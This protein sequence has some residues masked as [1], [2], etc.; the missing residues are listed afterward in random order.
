MTVGLSYNKLFKLLIDRNMKKGDLCVAANVAPS[1]LAKLRNGENVNT[2]ILVRICR[3]L[4]CEPGDI[5]EL[6]NEDAPEWRDAKMKPAKTQN[7]TTEQLRHICD[8]TVKY[9]CFTM[10]CEGMPIPER[11]VSDLHLLSR[12][13]LSGD[14]YRAKIRNEFNLK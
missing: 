4:Q 8:S 14:E 9:V 5:V 7:Q 2:D 1:S 13:E 10:A 12:G 3:T 6:N 11:E